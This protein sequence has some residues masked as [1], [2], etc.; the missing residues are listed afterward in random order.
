MACFFSF[1]LV[2]YF[3]RMC[4]CVSVF[5]IRVKTLLIERVSRPPAETSSSSW[6]ALSSSAPSRT[7]LGW[8]PRRRTVWQRAVRWTRPLCGGRWQW[9]QRLLPH[10]PAILCRR[11][12]Q[13]SSSSNLPR[14]RHRSRHRHRR[15][16]ASCRSCPSRPPRV[17]QRAPPLQRQRSTT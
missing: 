8:A 3:F 4:V 13:Y 9:P 12:R 6:R 14:H 10:S 2:S 11:R 5:E 16:S 7:H 1:N 17:L 15:P